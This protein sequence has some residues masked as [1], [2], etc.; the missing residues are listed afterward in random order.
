MSRCDLLWRR[1]LYL[2]GRGLPNR[3]LGSRRGGCR[4][5]GCGAPGLSPAVVG[6]CAPKAERRT[7]R[8]RPRL[9]QSA[10]GWFREWNG[11]RRPPWRGP[12]SG[13]DPQTAPSLG[14]TLHCILCAIG[15]ACKT[16]R[17]ESLGDPLQ[18]P[19]PNGDHVER[20]LEPHG[21]GMTFEPAVGR[22]AQAALL[23]VVHHLERIAEPVAPFLLHLAEHQPTSTPHHDVELV[24]G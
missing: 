14:R 21:L 19:A 20:H 18:A 11:L 6:G 7:S 2:R 24:A 16:Q 22:Q 9:R 1:S 3:R 12:P 13:E 8:R 23:F 4:S 15:S 10:F 5:S 17:S